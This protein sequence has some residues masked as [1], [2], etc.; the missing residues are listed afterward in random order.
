[1]GIAA[2]R[3]VGGYDESFSHN[4]DAELDFRLRQAGFRIWMTDKT[5][6]TYYPRASVLPLFRQYLGYGRGRA[7]NILKHRAWAETAADGADAGA[8]GRCRHVAC[9]SSCTG[10]P[11]GAGLDF[12]LPCLWRLE[13]PSA[14]GHRSARWQPFRPW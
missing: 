4:E 14:S 10:V 6:M 2:F 13:S 8:A 5:V 12:R 1:M 11:A 7:K 9:R 3:A